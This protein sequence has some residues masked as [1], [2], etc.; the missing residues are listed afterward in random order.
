MVQKK[1]M[2]AKRKTKKPADKP[3]KTNVETSAD[4][5]TPVNKRDQRSNRWKITLTAWGTAA[6][7][8]KFCKK[9]EDFV[10]HFMSLGWAHGGLIRTPE[11]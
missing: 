4:P 5:T 11:G 9:A 3:S 2:K 6:F 10:S 7:F 8:E 1:A